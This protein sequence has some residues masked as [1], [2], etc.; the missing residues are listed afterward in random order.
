MVQAAALRAK[1]VGIPYHTDCWIT[2][3]TRMQSSSLSVAV[4]RYGKMRTIECDYLACGYH[5]VA[6]TELASLLNCRIENG[7]VSVDEWQQTS[8]PNIFCAGEPTGIGGIEASIVEGKI[9]GYAATGNEPA[10]RRLFNERDKTQQ[11]AN[12]LTK[13]FELR[14]EL[15]SLAS[16][17]TFVCRCEDVTLKRLREFGNWREAKLQTRCGMGACQGRVCGPATEFLFG[18]KTDSVRP[19]IFPVKLENL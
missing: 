3:C 5:L 8:Q 11:F 7:F 2:E 15:R 9:T 19:P 14:G 6:S 4:T 13:A 18:W 12:R 1:L 16:E 10:A 17:K